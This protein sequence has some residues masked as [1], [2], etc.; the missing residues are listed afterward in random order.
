MAYGTKK[1]KLWRTPDENGDFAELSE[2]QVIRLKERAFNY[3]VWSLSQAPK[4][5]KQLT[6][7]MLQKNCPQDILD[8]TIQRLATYNYV[9]DEDFARSYISAKRSSGWGDRK[10]S[11]ELSKKGVER[12]TADSLL[13]P[14]EEEETGLF[15]EESEYDRAKRFAERKVRTI[16]AKLE[17]RK[18]VDRTVG[19]MVRRGFPIGMSYEIAGSLI[20]DTPEEE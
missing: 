7:K 14:P 12:E 5:V 16:P 19:A 13:A 2:K 9:N 6:D 8:E 10:I 1:I 3:C 20:Q 15:A 4:T 18:K 11:M 17:R